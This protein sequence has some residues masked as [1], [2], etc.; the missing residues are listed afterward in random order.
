MTILRYHQYWIKCADCEK[1]S[2]FPV[3]EHDGYMLMRNPQDRADVRLLSWEDKT[4]DEVSSLAQRCEKII[5]EKIVFN[6]LHKTIITNVINSAQIVFSL[7]CDLSDGTKYTFG[8]FPVCSYC[9]SH[10]IEGWGPTE[11]P[12]ETI[13]AEYPFITHQHWDILNQTE[14]ESIVYGEVLRVIKEKLSELENRDLEK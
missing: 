6:S 4:F 10:N 12:Y 1:E 8:S 14:K 11:D 3:Y 9:R 7:I 5:L 13:D 2:R